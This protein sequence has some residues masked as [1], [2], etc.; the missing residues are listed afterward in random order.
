MEEASRNTELYSPC[1]P[2]SPRRAAASVPVATALS[3]WAAIRLARTGR[4]DS[5]APRR[6][7]DS[8]KSP[9]SELAFGAVL[10]FA[11]AQAAGVVAW[12]HYSVAHSVL[13]GVVCSLVAADLVLVAVAWNRR[14][15]QALRRVVVI[16]DADFEQQVRKLAHQGGDRVIGSWTGVRTEFQAVGAVMPECE[17]LVV[18]VEAV[19]R[20]A[21]TL[22]GM[23]THS[24]VI[25][26]STE[27]LHRHQ[28]RPFDNPLP[29]AARAFKRAVDVGIVMILLLATS[30]ILLVAAL[31][32]RLESPGNVIFRQVRIGA[33]GRRF[34]CYKLRTMTA[35]ND[36][37]V[38]AAYVAALIDGEATATRGM[39]KLVADPR[40]TRVGRL[41]RRF[42]IDELPQ[43]WNVASGDMSLV[44]PRP[45]LPH[46]FERYDG[47]ALQR[48][49]VKPGLTGLWQV[50]GR[51]ERTFA[52]MVALDNQYWHCWSPLL[53]LRI[54]LRTPGAIL[55]G[56]GAA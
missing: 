29:P 15:R 56:R 7:T 33:D 2:S 37:S 44:G 28:G 19:G 23:A 14:G 41:L 20:L 43:L 46:E 24:Q 9:R 8:E 22:D 3:R 31:L 27:D 6:S 50:S 11:S 34:T 52:E 1:A 40:I 30:P 4:C 18:Q 10:L 35:D 12:A 54:L 17:L 51:C 49:R 48:L 55:R 16:G 42:S 32:I 47:T 53:E 26:L 21:S 45:P 25:A 5:P 36:D 38:S 13:A 39:Y